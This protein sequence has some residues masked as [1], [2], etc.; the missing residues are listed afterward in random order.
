MAD[1]LLDVQQL[2]HSF[3]LGKRV[4]IKAVD[5]LSFQVRKGEIFGLVGESGSGKS[6]A[7]RCVMNVYRPSSGK[8]IY[9]GINVCD[10]KEFRENKKLLQASRQ[11]IFQDSTSSLNE[12]MTVAEIIAEPM[13]IHRKKPPRGTLRREAEFQL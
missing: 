12:R 9:K 8:I 4:A 13:K 2:T 11:F 7:A 3:S 10:P 1:V 6:T 5:N